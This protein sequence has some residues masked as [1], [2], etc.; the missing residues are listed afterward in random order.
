MTCPRHTLK[1]GD[2]LS[3]RP[4]LSVFH[5]YLSRVILVAGD[6]GSWRFR[7]LSPSS[8]VLR[9]H[10]PFKNTYVICTTHWALKC[11]C[12][13]LG[14]F[15][16]CTLWIALLSV[17]LQELLNL[18]SVHGHPN[19]RTA[20]PSTSCEVFWAALADSSTGTE[21]WSF[22]W[23]SATSSLGSKWLGCLFFPCQGYHSSEQYLY[24]VYFI[25][26]TYQL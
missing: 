4:L 16:H 26:R 19:E 10:G 1:S 22:Y 5:A 3:V 20:H 8:L 6:G 14:A 9:H 25:L 15:W 7:L 13:S 12:Q 18:A 17:D 2:C 24:I 11:C 23:S 21:E